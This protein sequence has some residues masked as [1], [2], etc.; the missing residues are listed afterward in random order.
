MMS[1]FCLICNGIARHFNLAIILF[2][3]SPKL[4][5]TATGHSWVVQCRLLQVL[6][7]QSSPLSP[8]LDLVRHFTWRDVTSHATFRASPSAFSTSTPDEF[9]TAWLP[10][11]A[12]CVLAA[13]S[14]A[15]AHS[16]VAQ[17]TCY[18]FLMRASWMALNS[19]YH[20]K[21]WCVYWRYFVNPM[22]GLTVQTP[23][24]L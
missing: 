16:N 5:C 14:K 10:A 20:S 3:I 6:V 2:F 22:S 8:Y 12:C 4:P 15:S 1:L 24:P 21:E 23:M 19:Q 11:V 13:P 7:L 18:I 9:P 17:C